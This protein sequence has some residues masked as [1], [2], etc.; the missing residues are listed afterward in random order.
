MDVQEE[1]IQ[2]T[3]T[4]ET[5]SESW[6]KGTLSPVY[7]K[8]DKLDCTNYLSICL[9]NVA[10]KVFATVLYD[11]LLPYANAVVQHYQAGFQ[12]CK[13][14]KDQLFALRQILEEGNEYNNQTHHL[15]ID[16]TASYYTIIRN[17]VYVSMSVLSFPSKLIRLTT[18]TLNMNTVLCCVKIQNDCSGDKTFE[19]VK[20]F[21]YLG[22]L[23]TP[24]N[25]VSLQI[26]RRI[27]TVNR[28]S[29]GICHVQQ[30]SS[31]T[32]P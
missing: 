13:S 29:R 11:H 22:S 21:V 7:K 10:Y 28:C 32:R 20:E 24:N 26:Q 19:V 3:W 25:D 31:S 6:T 14:T 23:V 30:N 1:V 2:L 18:A 17:E 12:S 9:L 4:S 27:Q 16:F 8:G 5:L 15:F